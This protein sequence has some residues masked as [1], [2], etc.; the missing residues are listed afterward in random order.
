MSASTVMTHEQW[1]ELVS[2]NDEFAKRAAAR[3]AADEALKTHLAAAIPAAT[4]D[5][6]KYACID[7]VQKDQ[8]ANLLSDHAK[9]VQ[10]IRKLAARVATPEPLGAPDKTQVKQANQQNRLVTDPLATPAAQEL[11]EKSKSWNLSGN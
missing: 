11:Y 3:E 9:C 10:F 7:V 5:L 6:V 4:E 1:D 8:V 2:L